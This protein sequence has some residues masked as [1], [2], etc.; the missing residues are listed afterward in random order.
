MT[1]PNL[2]TSIRIILTPIFFIY[3]IDGQLLFALFVFIIAGLTDAFDGLVARVWGQK[4]RMGAI[5]DPLADKLLIITAFIILP[6]KTHSI[7]VWLSVIV[8]S[9]DILILLGVL[10]LFLNSI[11]FEVRPSIISK[12]T[13]CFQLITVILALLAEKM[14]FC[15]DIGMYLHI[16]TGLVTI[17]S[18][19]HYMAFWFR[20]LG[21]NQ[22]L[23]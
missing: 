16:L 20:L 8:I 14:A 6:I 18:G 3:V 15:I 19:L 11:K 12:I 4:S 17:I 1:V 21:E 5:L 13:T 7:P 9:R 2:L 10:I 22:I 23:S